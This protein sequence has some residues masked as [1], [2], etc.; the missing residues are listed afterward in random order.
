MKR[1]QMLLGISTIAA[2]ILFVVYEY[3]T[4][5][6]A[7]GAQGWASIFYIGTAILLMVWFLVSLVT[8]STYPDWKNQSNPDEQTKER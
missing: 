7:I 5:F 2:L 6:L 4:F 3:Y 8:F 1:E